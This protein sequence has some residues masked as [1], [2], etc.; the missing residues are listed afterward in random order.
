MG[1]KTYKVGFSAECEV[2]IKVP[3]NTTE[4]E[5]IEMAYKV[6]NRDVKDF[7]IQD[8]HLGYIHTARGREIFVI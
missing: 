1:T 4:D 8:A 3:D 6:V 7:T 5:L 2:E